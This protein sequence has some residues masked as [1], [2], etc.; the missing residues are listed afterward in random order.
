[1]A[2]PI[3]TLRIHAYTYTCEMYEGTW[4]IKRSENRGIEVLIRI[5]YDY[6]EECETIYAVAMRYYQ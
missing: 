4:K 2:R 6:A 3:I 1:M 5:R